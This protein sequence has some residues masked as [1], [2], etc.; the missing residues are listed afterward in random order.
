[1]VG[2]VVSGPT[3]GRGSFIFPPARRSGWSSPD[4]ARPARA[5]AHAGRARRRCR[6]RRAAAVGRRLS[7]TGAAG[8]RPTR[9]ITRSRSSCARVWRP[10]SASIPHPP[11]SQTEIVSSSRRAITARTSSASIAEPATRVDGRADAYDG[12]RRAEH[13]D[14]RHI[15]DQAARHLTWPTAGESLGDWL[16]GRPRAH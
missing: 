7:R 5:I 12:H 10:S 1:M 9:A 14:D 3:V 8:R 6:D 15:I 16:V 2:G 11:S 4:R 13:C